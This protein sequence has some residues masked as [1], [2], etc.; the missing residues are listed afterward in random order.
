MNNARCPKCNGEFSADYGEHTLV[1]PFCGEKT[2]AVRARKY[3]A[4]FHDRAAT[5]GE[6]HGDKLL[7][8]EEYLRVGAHELRQED[9]GA[10]KEAYLKA[11]QINPRDYR[12]FMGL[13]AAC[14]KN[15]TDFKDTEHREYLQKA[16]AVADE[17]QQKNIAATYRAYEAKT[18][19]TDSEYDEYLAE[20]QKDYKSHIKK[21]II[22]FSKLIDDNKKKAKIAYIS[23]FAMIG[24][25]VVLIV[26]GL[27]FSFIWMVLPGVILIGG[28][29][30][31]VA[32]WSRQ[33][34]YEKLYD[35]LVALFNAM[36]DFKFDIPQTDKVLD[37]MRTILYSVKD[38]D[39]VSATGA[40][41]AALVEFLKSTGNK[42]AAVFCETQKFAEKYK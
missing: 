13:V 42:Q 8:F 1:C 9:F 6:A 29:Y 33:R 32:V 14:T 15:Y 3:F 4:V 2:D 19:M 17:E 11:T 7:K 20:K 34:F 30:A 23:M 36:K 21:A 39:P 27:I 18:S 35:F 41:V 10:A 31:A 38:G 12:G 25:G 5:E 40:K 37:H 22:A 28:S 16:F 26:L 24:V